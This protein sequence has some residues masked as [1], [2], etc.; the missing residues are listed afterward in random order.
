[1]TIQA[2][3]HLYGQVKKRGK[4]FV[5][6]CGPLDL[7]TQGKTCEEAKGNLIE[8]SQLFLTSCIERR[9]FDQALKELG[10]V[11]LG[12]NAPEEPLPSG[13]FQFPVSILWAFQKQTRCRG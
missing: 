13:A 9:T 5:A 2:E 10:L 1:M 6:Y 4:W 7:S 12:D 11:P 3:F 8:A